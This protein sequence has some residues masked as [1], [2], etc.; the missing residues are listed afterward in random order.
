M[1]F[2]VIL[3]TRP[4]IIKMSPV[5]RELR[6]R[7]AD[8]IIIHTNQHYSYEMDQIFFEALELP[9]PDFNLNIGSGTHGE[10][11]GKM[12]TKIEEIL[13]KCH[14]DVVLVQGDTNTVLAGALAAAKLGIIV[15]HVE[16]GLRSYDRTMPEEL[17]RIVT[18]HISNH[19]FVPTENAKD[20]LIREGISQEKIFVTG[21]TIVDAVYQNL[22]I[23]GKKESILKELGIEGTYILITSHR[24]ENVDNR[25]NLENI[26]NA[27]SLISDKTGYILVYP[28]HPRTQMRLK[29]FGFYEKAT[30]IPNLK[31]I[32]PVGFFE[33][34]QLESCAK[35]ILTDSGGIQEEACILNTPCV[36]L[37]ENTERPETI[38]AGANMLAGTDSDRIFEC[39]IESLDKKCKWNNPFG[40][41]AAA[42][43]IIDIIL[44][45]N[46]NQNP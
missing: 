25:N 13:I 21:N 41:G 1:K 2:A 35:L 6:R 3:G 33:F 31:L 10:Q 43:K 7:G 46:S 4:E 15:G 39:V 37:R 20:N 19:L 29:E 26:L 28:V 14:P 22:E 42:E 18:D 12:I 17:N 5:I 36:T 30:S 9:V 24:Q 27:L 8:Y 45:K 34:L 16:A 11:T 38:A 32:N 23:S 44:S 40:D